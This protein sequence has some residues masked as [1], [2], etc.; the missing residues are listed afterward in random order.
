MASILQ[1]IGES[2]AEFSSGGGGSLD[3]T[4]AA[5]LDLV[6]DGDVLLL[7]AYGATLGTPTGGGWVV[8]WSSGGWQAWTKSATAREAFP[9]LAASD[10]GDDAAGVLVVYRRGSIGYLVGVAVQT[11]TSGVSLHSTPAA[12]VL[13][14]NGLLLGLWLG[15]GGGLEPSYP[16]AGAQTVAA[17][18]TS[19]ASGGGARWFVVVEAPITAVPNAGTMALSTG[20]AADMHIAIVPL[21]DRPPHAPGRLVDGGAGAN[22]GL[23]P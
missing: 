23:L 16:P 6:A 13:D 22:I 17:Q 21:R 15:S 1:R 9:T 7:V 14:P 4:D 12:T 20:G 11:S 8:R 3:F 10:G 18:K 5:L 2:A 19:N